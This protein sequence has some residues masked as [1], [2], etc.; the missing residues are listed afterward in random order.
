MASPV[1]HVKHE[2]GQRTHSQTGEQAPASWPGAES[3][4]WPGLRSSASGDR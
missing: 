2:G 1:L 4:G 3:W